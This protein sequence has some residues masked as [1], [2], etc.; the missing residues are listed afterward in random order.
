MKTM[1]W[2]QKHET[3]NEFLNQVPRWERKKKVNCFKTFTTKVSHFVTWIS[4]ENFASQRQRGEK[5]DISTITVAIPSI[6][7]V[8]ISL[9]HKDNIASHS[10]QLKMIFPSLVPD[11]WNILLMWF[12]CVICRYHSFVYDVTIVC[13]RNRWRLEKQ[14]NASSLK[15]WLPFTAFGTRQSSR[16]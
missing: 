6:L 7:A 1:I 12:F 3:R 5:F 4:M 8:K 16:A 11:S 14:R 15:D 2:K 13:W 10:N 9:L